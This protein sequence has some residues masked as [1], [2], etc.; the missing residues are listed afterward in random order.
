[1]KELQDCHYG[2][3]ICYSN[4]RL[5]CWNR[6]GVSIIKYFVIFVAGNVSGRS[7]RRGGIG[8]QRHVK[9]ILSYP[10]YGTVSRPCGF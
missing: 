1:M 4:I 8:A 5:T 6:H 3:S 2:Y 10:G 7:D 9:S